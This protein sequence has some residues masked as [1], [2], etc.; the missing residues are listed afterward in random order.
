MDKQDFYAL[1]ESLVAKGYGYHDSAY[2]ERVV[3]SCPC[4]RCG[5]VRYYY[6]MKVPQKR[7]SK[8]SFRAFAVCK[9]CGRVDEY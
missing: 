2:D 7:R 4:P 3:R 5:H 9:H 8:L 6:G 1:C